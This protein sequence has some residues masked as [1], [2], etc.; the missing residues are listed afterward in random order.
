MV[1]ASQRVPIYVCNFS[2]F[3][4]CHVHISLHHI[5]V[6]YLQFEPL[7]HSPPIGKEQLLPIETSRELP[8]PSD[9]LQVLQKDS[10]LNRQVLLF[11]V[12]LLLSYS[13]NSFCPP[14]TCCG[15]CCSTPNFH[16]QLQHHPSQPAERPDPEQGHFLRRWSRNCARDYHG[17]VLSSQ[18]PMQSSLP[19][20]GV[21]K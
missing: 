21:F 2:C 1:V 20:G 18:V 8:G 13:F 3:I 15:T 17:A 11:S 14:C 19:N 10:G 4:L 6:F 7:R 12:L 16:P 9:P 5:L